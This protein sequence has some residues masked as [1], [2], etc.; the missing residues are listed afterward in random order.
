MGVEW[1]RKPTG[2]DTAL[3]IGVENRDDTD[4]ILGHGW[5]H[6]HHHGQGQDHGKDE[7]TMTKK[8]VHGDTDLKVVRDG[9]MITKGVTVI[10]V[11][12]DHEKGATDVVNTIGV[13]RRRVIVINIVHGFNVPDNRK[14][15]YPLRPSILRCVSF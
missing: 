9:M 1:E 11:V 8:S 3:E 7:E 13:D 12:Q 5:G 10:G 2:G 6:G 15:S 14:K 4:H